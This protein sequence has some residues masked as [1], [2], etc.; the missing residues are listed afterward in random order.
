MG[1]FY[2]FV[3]RSTRNCPAKLL[4]FALSKKQN[5]IKLTQSHYQEV[6]TQ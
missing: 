2:H 3:W 4:V 6:V 1:Y 5:S